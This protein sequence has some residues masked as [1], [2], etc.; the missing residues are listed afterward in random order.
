MGRPA[1]TQH[2][3]PLATRPKRLRR[4]PLHAAR[5][6]YC[7]PKGIPLHEFLDWPTES[8]NAALTW[9]ANE[10]TRC[11]G[12][13]THTEDWLRPDGRRGDEPVH[14]HRTIC[15]GCAARESA[16]K[17]AESVHGLRVVA[18]SG[19]RDSCPSCA[20]IEEDR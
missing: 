15:P 10:A 11:S 3:G 8:Q 14:Y 7:G 9:Q 13:G 5:M 20:R 6:A 2:N 12:C 17:G 4:D 16:S 1:A 19:P 18:V